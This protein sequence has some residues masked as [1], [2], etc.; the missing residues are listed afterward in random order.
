MGLIADGES[1]RF[2]YVQPRSALA[3]RGVTRGTVLFDGQRNGNT[4]Q[5]TAR[6]FRG[7]ACGSFTYSVSGPVSADQRSVTMYGKAPQVDAA[8]RVTGS[9]DDRLHFTLR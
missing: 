2:V 5:G 8:C 6:I 4:Y 3:S 9:I 7:G 1:R